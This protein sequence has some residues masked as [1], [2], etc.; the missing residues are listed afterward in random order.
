MGARPDIVEA[1]CHHPLE[2]ISANSLFPGAA[3]QDHLQA[4]GKTEQEMRLD[5]SEEHDQIKF[6]QQPIEN[7]RRPSAGDPKADQ[8]GRIEAVVIVPAV[9]RQVLLADFGFGFRLRHRAMHAQSE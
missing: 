6:R 1:V 2:M 8:M 3:R 9:S 5:D 7:D 4:A